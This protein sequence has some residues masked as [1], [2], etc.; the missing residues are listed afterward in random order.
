MTKVEFERRWRLIMGAP[1]N[2]PHPP[3]AKRGRHHPVPR[4][5]TADDQ[6]RDDVLNQLYKPAPPKRL[7]MDAEQLE[8]TKTWFEN[9]EGLF[10]PDITDLLHQD[11]LEKIGIVA[12]IFNPDLL[13]YFKPTPQLIYQLLENRQYLPDETL[14]MIE[15]LIQQL[16]QDL[17]RQLRTP[18][19]QAAKGI[20]NRTRSIPNP[21]HDNINW[22]RTILANLKHYQ[23]DYQTII[24]AK[25]VG[26]GRKQ[27]HLPHLMICVDKSGSMFE[28]VIYATVFG[29]VLATIPSLHTQ[30]ILFDTRVVDVSDQLDKPAQLLLQTQLGGNTNLQAP[31]TYINQHLEQ[32]SQ[33]TLVMI[34]DLFDHGD[35]DQLVASF[36]H[37]HNTGLQIIL[38]LALNDDGKPRYNHALARQLAKRDIICFACPARH[39][40]DLMAAALDHQDLR[41]WAADQDIVIV[42][43]E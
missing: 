31:L 43:P 33:T 15:P 30:L 27:P 9:A 5:F 25:L 4:P 34:T 17:M 10:D 6:R 28:S 19:E 39:F 22:H 20:L 35:P 40:P 24:P 37:L 41:R 12:L 18:T 42:T 36:Q 29:A 13:E 8:E 26:Y 3:P 7:K 21:R 38:L 23:P 16:I 14:A 32:P 2:D 1:E 11:M